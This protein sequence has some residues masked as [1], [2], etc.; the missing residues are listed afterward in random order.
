MLLRKPKLRLLNKIPLRTNRASLS[1]VLIWL[2][3][4]SACVDSH[5][6]QFTMGSLL[7]LCL[8]NVW[9]LR[10]CPEAWYLWDLNKCLL[11]GLPMGSA[12]L[13]QGHLSSGHIT[14]CP[15]RGT[16]KLSRGHAVLEKEHLH[17]FAAVKCHRCQWVKHMH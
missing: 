7:S 14:K 9:T 13:L 11:T 16:R 17:H 4:L 3:S 5:S 12:L 15:A 6:P 2:L 1:S 8:G 10:T